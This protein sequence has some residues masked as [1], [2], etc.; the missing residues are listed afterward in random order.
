M[1]KTSVKEAEQEEVKEEL[2]YAEKIADLTI[3]IDKLKEDL[4]TS[5][6]NYDE[7]ESKFNDE[8]KANIRLM[9]RISEREESR[10]IEETKE[11]AKPVKITDF[12]NFKNGRLELKK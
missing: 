1:A 12:Y 3:Q 4:A 11:K 10:N 5:K 8:H 7:L 9:S 6:N 2:D